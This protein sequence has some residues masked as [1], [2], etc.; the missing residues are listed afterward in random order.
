MTHPSVNISVR[1]ALGLMALRLVLFFINADFPYQEEIF[2]FLLLAAF[3]LLTIYAIWPRE[4]KTDFKRDA[5]NSL[6]LNAVF[7]V[8]MAIFI[9]AFYAFADTN[10]FP[11]MVDMITAREF[12]ANPD[13]DEAELRRG[14]EQFFSLRNFSVL[15]VLFFL[16]MGV[17]YAVLLSALKRLVIR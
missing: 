8:A 4:P 10:Y 5:L 11:N 15:A 3:P 17:F 14:V 12:E 2:L 1:V 13:L 16:A 7:S 9:Y 6:R